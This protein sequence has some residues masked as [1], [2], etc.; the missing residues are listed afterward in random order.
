MEIMNNKL[1]MSKLYNVI[2]YFNKG[3]NNFRFKLLNSGLNDTAIIDTK[4]RPNAWRYLW[5]SF[6]DDL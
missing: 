6:E 4:N 2:N 3:F 1:N 5:E